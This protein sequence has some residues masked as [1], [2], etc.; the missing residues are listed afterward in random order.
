MFPLFFYFFEADCW[1]WPGVTQTT[2]G[3][4]GKEKL[5]KD[6]WAWTVPSESMDPCRSESL[7][8]SIWYFFGAIFALTVFLFDDYS[9]GLCVFQGQCRTQVHTIWNALDF[10]TSITVWLRTSTR[11]K[12]NPRL[13]HG[14]SL[15]GSMLS[16]NNVHH[17]WTSILVLSSVTSHPAPFFPARQSR[18][19]PCVPVSAAC[20]VSTSSITAGCSVPV[21]GR[22]EQIYLGGRDLKNQK[23]LALKT[24]L[25]TLLWLGF[26]L[27]IYQLL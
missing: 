27:F 12:R 20:P 22:R 8:L 14:V 13:G 9:A 4:G 19:S 2:C 18:M 6:P 25:R 10:T 7:F 3:G 26:L 15:R 21:H 24:T 16:L 1:L 17:L 11:L 23:N 5:C